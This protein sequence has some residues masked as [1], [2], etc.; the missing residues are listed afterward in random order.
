MVLHFDGRSVTR[1]RVPTPR[2]LTGIAALD[3]TRMCVSGYQGTLL[4]GNAG[5][6]RPLITNTSDPLLT[7]AALDGKAYYG[8]ESSVWSTDGVAPPEPEYDFPARWVSALTDGLVFS[9][10]EAAMLCKDGVLTELSVS[11]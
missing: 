9:H 6:W 3:A 10:G 7:V 4:V 2:I 5:G 1:L 8:V 11:L